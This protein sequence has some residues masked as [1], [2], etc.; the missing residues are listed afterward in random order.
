MAGP[1]MKNE[2]VESVF[3]VVGPEDRHTDAES[4]W[5]RKLLGAWLPII[6][7]LGRVVVLDRPESRLAF[8]VHEAHATGKTPVCIHFLP[9]HKIYPVDGAITVAATASD[10]VSAPDWPVGGDVRWRW[11]RT[12]PYIDT[13]LTT[14]PATEDAFRDAGFRGRS[15]VVPRLGCPDEFPVLAHAAAEGIEVPF[16]RPGPAIVEPAWQEADAGARGLSSR[17][18][19][20]IRRGYYRFA[21]PLIPAAI[22][23][24]VLRKFQGIKKFLSRS[25]GSAPG[26]RVILNPQGAEVTVARLD[27]LSDPT[28]VAELLLAYRRSLGD[29]PDRVLVAEIPGRWEESVKALADFSARMPAARARLLAVAEGTDEAWA[30]RRLAAWAVAT[31][32]DRASMEWAEAMLGLGVPLMAPGRGLSAPVGAAW[33][34]IALAGA[35]VPSQL[36]DDPEGLMCLLALRARYDEIE[37]ALLRTISVHSGSK[38]HATLREMARETSRGASA[39][40]ARDVLER[41]LSTESAIMASLKAA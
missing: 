4:V 33:P 17:A 12:V 2:Q 6:R 26:Q 14:V 16:G 21:R 39:R 41:A 15:W 35:R 37:R 27:P 18:W 29:K 19:F 20:G 25:R 22:H 11:S 31:G 10:H 32:A 36:A 8:H 7:Q 23:H 9:V 1:E 38:P 40:L 30:F 5:H 3:L 13:L 28:G 24:A 34:G